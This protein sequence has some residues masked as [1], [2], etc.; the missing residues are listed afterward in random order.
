MT[1]KLAIP[2]TSKLRKK[3][4]IYGVATAAFQI[5][6]AAES[7]LSCIWDTFCATPGKVSDN[8]DGLVACDHLRLWQSDL[9]LIESLQVDAYRF[10]VSWGR[11]INADGSLNHS[12]V[13]FY[14]KLL[15]RLAEKNIKAFVTLYHWDLPQHLEDK[16]GWLNRE[17]AYLFEDYADKISRVFG[18][19]VHSY[20][21]LN[22]PFCSAFLGYEKG[23]HAPGIADLGAGRRAAHHLLLAHGLAL[24]VLNKNSPKSLNGLVLNMSPTY[25]KSDSAGDIAAA[26]LADDFLFQWYAQPV[27]AGSYPEKAMAYI[28]EHQRPPIEDGDMAIISQ[29]M[30]Y[31][32]LNY[33]TRA[34]FHAE[35]DTAFVETV[36]A[37]A[38]LTDMGWEIFPQGLTDLLVNLH[39]RYPLPP[40]FIT[41]N[42]AA[43]PDTV[44]NGEV[45]DIDRL[46]YYDSHLNAIH[47]AVEQGVDVKGYFAWSLM[48]N[49]EWAYGYQKRFGI[50][51]VDYET[52]TRTI[53]ASGHAY[54][55]FI[56][57]R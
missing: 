50:V 36:P 17:T 18:H 54:A 47:N 46:A 14:I 2:Q 44:E 42:G 55:N 34:I 29:P 22:E 21:T 48:D 40:V 19:R 9:D 35:A 28:P 51:Y 30:D 49:F 32:G 1:L 15:D 24:R 43:M 27:L 57:S 38:A 4:F 31:L 45:N 12:G 3:D 41:E 7:R 10:S 56:G 53:K 6:G 37:D 26:Q 13:A 25:P 33:Y 20:A 39:Q 5:E 11:V 8:A 52:Q 16:G 23:I